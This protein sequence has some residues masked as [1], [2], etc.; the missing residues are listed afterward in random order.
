MNRTPTFRTPAYRPPVFRTAAVIGAGT[1]GLSWTALFA[2]HGLTVRVSDPRDDLA[3]AVA[4][5]LARYAPHLAA[6]GLDVRGLADR[7]HLAA[8]VTEAV[9]DAD[10]VQENGPERVGFKQ[11]LFAAVVREAPAHALLLSSSSAIPATAF[12][13]ELTDEDAARVLIGH[14][15][16]PPHLLPLVEVVPGERTGEDA[17][18]AA[19]GFYTFLGRTPVV[20]RKEIPGFVGNRLQNALSREA[21]HLVEQGVVTPEDLDRVV[22]NSLGPRWATVGPFLGA[23]LGGGPG[24]YRHLV[25]HIGASMRALEDAPGRR[26]AQTPDQQERLIEAVE[27]A[28]GSSTYSELAETRDRKQLAV[29]DALDGAARTTTPKE[30]N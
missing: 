20:E 24:G 13:G 26:P 16:N 2:A 30:E 18:Q 4:D 22:T 12:T 19:L 27:K 17:V 25:A 10:V 11:D 8:D 29:L 6:R 14:P 3:E 5:A 7:V 9:R 23:H 15:F 1:I 21:V 28:Y